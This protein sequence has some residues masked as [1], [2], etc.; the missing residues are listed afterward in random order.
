MISIE[1]LS[2]EYIVKQDDYFIT[3][4]T[5]G[6]VLFEIEKMLLKEAKK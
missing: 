4:Q 2:K 6:N 1:K 3:C 5:V